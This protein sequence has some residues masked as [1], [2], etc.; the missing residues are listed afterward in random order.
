MKKEQEEKEVWWEIVSNH[1]VMN[2]DKGKF[3]FLIPDGY[4]ICDEKTNLDKIGEAFHIAKPLQLGLIKRLDGSFNVAAFFKTNPME[5][6]NFDDTQGLIDGIHK[7]MADNQGLVEV[8]NGKTKRGY[9]YIYSIVKTVGDGKADPYGV[10][11]FIRL[12][13]RNKDSI[14]EMF[15]NFEEQGI[16]GI[17]ESTVGCIA[18]SVGICELGKEKWFEDPYD[19][20]YTRGVPKNLAEREG[21]DGL[22]PENP[23]TQAHEFLY[24]ILNNTLVF[25]KKSPDENLSENREQL[26]EEQK[27]QESREF[28]RGL[29]EEKCRRHTVEVEV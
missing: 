14:L 26:T 4:E 22:F 15:A 9:D 11:Y 16:T 29:F 10:R 17:R 21:L 18:D 8:R 1:V 20:A 12:N 7:S 27:E 25:I 5:S 3:H 24:A 2:V 6:M 23:L 28:L 19:S 13:L